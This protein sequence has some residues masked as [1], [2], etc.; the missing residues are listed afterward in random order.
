MYNIYLCIYIYMYN[1]YIYI[2]THIYIYS[3]ECTYVYRCVMS[4]L[5]RLSNNGE[6]SGNGLA[7]HQVS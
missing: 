7:N 4:V 1:I 3:Y 6:I 5:F 2:H